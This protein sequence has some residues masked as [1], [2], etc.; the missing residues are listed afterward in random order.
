MSPNSLESISLNPETRRMLDD[1]IDII[2]RYKDKINITGAKNRTEIIDNLIYPS[3]ISTQLIDRKKISYLDIGTGSGILGISLK[4]VNNS[5]TL[6]LC[7]NNLKKIAFLN[8]VVLK[9]NIKNVNIWPS[10]LEELQLNR[11]ENVDQLLIRGIKLVHI[12][13][14]LLE[15]FPRGTSLIY[16]GSQKEVSATSADVV[17]SLP[18][19]GNEEREHP[20]HIFSLR[21]K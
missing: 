16:Y 6:N 13:R 3:I 12:Y 1:Y 20:I 19:P 2:M 5:V 4:I 14:I 18:I 10:S 17:E 21:L 9:L 15:K 8:E 11:L 7:D